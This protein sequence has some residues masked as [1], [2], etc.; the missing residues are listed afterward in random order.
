MTTLSFSQLID[1][2]TIALNRGDTSGAL[3]FFQEAATTATPPIVLS[4]LGYC[5]AKEKGENKKG[6][7]LC[8]EALR[9]EPKNA[10]H[11]LNLGRTC[12]LNGQ[13]T[14]AQQAFRKG[15]TYQRHH[16]IIAELKKMGVRR[17]PVFSSLSRENPLN[18]YFG[19]F[20]QRL[21]LR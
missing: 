5:L 2:G 18:R 13:K 6:R 3:V 16:G 11:Y 8:M 14:V 9:E 17:Q 1:Q 19:Y 10:L 12:L 4:C 15:L 21:G 20:F 7:A